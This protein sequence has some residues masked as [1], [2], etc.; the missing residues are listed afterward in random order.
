MRRAQGGIRGSGLGVLD[1][2]FGTR[3]SCPA[4]RNAT[5]GGYDGQQPT[6]IPFETLRLRPAG[7]SVAPVIDL[8]FSWYGIEPE[9]DCR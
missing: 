5:A 8:L 4:A 3:G 1:S 2:G 7:K 6:V 9:I